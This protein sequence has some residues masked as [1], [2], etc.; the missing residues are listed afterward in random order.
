VEPFCR[1]WRSSSAVRSF[2]PLLPVLLFAAF[3]VGCGG[4]EGTTE[5][6][7][8]LI[9]RVELPP[10]EEIERALPQGAPLRA[11]EAATKEAKPSPAPAAPSVK[12]GMVNTRILNVRRSP[13]RNAERVGVLPRGEQ[14]VI[15]QEE[16]GWYHI[17]AYAGYLEGWTAKNY[18]EVS[19]AEEPAGPPP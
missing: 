13:D 12:R 14:V 9:A 4:G 19:P 5:K 2:S 1:L 16:D 3:Y 10:V 11:R 6:K 18:I 15:L 7:A 17:Q 8:P